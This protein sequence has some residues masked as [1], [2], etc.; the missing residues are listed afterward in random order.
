MLR[1]CVS[2]CAGESSR[3]QPRPVLQLRTMHG[4]VEAPSVVRPSKVC[5]TCHPS[6][7]SAGKS[8][9]TSLTRL[10]NVTRS[11]VLVHQRSGV[12]R[13]RVGTRGCCQ[14]QNNRVLVSVQ[15]RSST[16]C[17]FKDCSRGS[18]DTWHLFDPAEAAVTEFAVCHITKRPQSTMNR[19]ERRA[20]RVSLTISSIFMEEK[21]V[22]ASRLM[23]FL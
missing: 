20:E 21:S 13:P 18:T 12:V 8:R 19:R 10:T 7:A 3:M 5:F 4:G 2:C 9:A 11:R 1:E 22:A 17:L 6:P 15:D 23:A 14:S 16:T